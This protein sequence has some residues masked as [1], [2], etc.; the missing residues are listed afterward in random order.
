MCRSLIFGRLDAVD[1]KISKKCCKEV[2][3][4]K[5]YICS[6]NCEKEIKEILYVPEKEKCVSTNGIEY[7][8]KKINRF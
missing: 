8:K 6:E 1:E 3:K 5:H 7:S 4:M 2:L